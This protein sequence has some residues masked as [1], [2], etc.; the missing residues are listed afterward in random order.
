MLGSHLSQNDSCSEFKYKKA[1]SLPLI[2]SQR[3]IGMSSQAVAKC[4]GTALRQGST[5]KGL[6]LVIP[7]SIALS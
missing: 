7:E 2:L 3:V 5:I 1:D 6:V 4:E